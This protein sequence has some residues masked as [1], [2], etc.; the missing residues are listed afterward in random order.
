[1]CLEQTTKVVNAASKIKQQGT[2]G[3]Y[4]SEFLLM[5]QRVEE[6]QKI[7]QDSNVSTSDLQQLQEMIDNKK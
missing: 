5:K 6:V 1:M 4:K 2:T 7:L 3:A